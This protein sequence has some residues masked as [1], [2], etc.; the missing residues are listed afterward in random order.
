MMPYLSMVRFARFTMMVAVSG[1]LLVLGAPAYAQQPA[2]DATAAQARTFFEQG[3]QFADQ[4]RWGEALEYFRRSRA[5]LERPRTVFNMGNALVRLGRHVET[6]QA[7]QD[8]WRIS[9][10]QHDAELRA[11]ATQMLGQSRAAIAH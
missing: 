1:A 9:D 4:E 2:N 5:L 6:V 11:L 10:P 8:F 7:L 3:V